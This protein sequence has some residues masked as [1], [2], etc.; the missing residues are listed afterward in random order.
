MDMCMDAGAAE[1]EVTQLSAKTFRNGSTCV[2]LNSKCLDIL[3]T[4]QS[5]VYACGLEEVNV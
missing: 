5:R 4:V 3:C 2:P 1:G